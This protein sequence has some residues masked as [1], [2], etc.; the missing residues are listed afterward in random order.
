MQVREEV[1]RVVGDRAPT[2]DDIKSLPY[3]RATLGESL[4]M[5]PQ[6]P[7]LIRRAL[8]ED[9]LPAGLGGDPA[10]WVEGQEACLLCFLLVFVWWLHC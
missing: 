8:N 5:Y 10:G 3:L 7:I 2:I 9:T 4:R 1:D 6:P